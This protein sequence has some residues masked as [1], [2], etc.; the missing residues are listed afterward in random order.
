[1]NKL[2]FVFPGQGSQYVGMGK[3]FYD[4]FA[5]A[6]KTFEEADDIFGYAISKLIFDG[7]K[8]GLDLTENTQPAILITSIAAL[9]VLYEKTDA[10]PDLL[11]GHSL[12]EFTALVASGALAFGDAV[13]LVHMRGKFMQASAPPGAGKMCAILGLDIEAV[14]VICESASM[15]AAVAVPANINSPEQIVI[16]GHACAVDIAAALA[17]ERGARMVVPLQVS[18]P[19]HSPLM[20]RAAQRLDEELQKIKFNDMEAP[21]IS[22][23]EAEPVTDPSRIRELLTR[24]MTSPVRWVDI[25]RRMKAEGVARVVEI[26]PNRVL[27]GLIKR[28]DKEISSF[29]LN[30]ASDIDRVVE[31]VKR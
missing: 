31:A 16:S 11:A 5:V 26:G 28:I 22:N 4:G 8:E 20:E 9:R 21:V 19:A 10:R 23:V 30:E 18:A 1:M 6:K 25:I 24:Q 3:S 15:D 7:P 14:S 27:T 2:A 13:R 12:G 29:N 17:K